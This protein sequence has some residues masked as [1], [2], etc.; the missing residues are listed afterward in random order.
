MNKIIGLGFIFC[1]IGFGAIDYAVI[2]IKNN[3][4]SSIIQEQTDIAESRKRE[5]LLLQQV[6]FL[7]Y[8][9]DV[10]STKDLK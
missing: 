2:I 5:D 7:E 3:I 4:K 1:G 6:K 8:Q 9:V 10:L